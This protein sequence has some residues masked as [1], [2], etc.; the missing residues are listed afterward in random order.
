MAS[1][2]NFFNKNSNKEKEMYHMP[3]ET[4]PFQFHGT[5][6]EDLNSQLESQKKSSYG[7]T[8]SSETQVFSQLKISQAR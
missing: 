7:G 1:E 3:K 5:K 8:D 4:K 6:E 2:A